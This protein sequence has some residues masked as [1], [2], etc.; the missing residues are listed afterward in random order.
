MRTLIGAEVM[1]VSAGTGSAPEDPATGGD[2]SLGENS[3]IPFNPDDSRN[4][5]WPPTPPRVQ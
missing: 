4:W 5:P 1:D 2:G 3:T